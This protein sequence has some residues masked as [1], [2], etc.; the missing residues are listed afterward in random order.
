MHHK[1]RLW[2]TNLHT[3]FNNI[4]RKDLEKESDLLAGVLREC[5]GI[6]SDFG[7]PVLSS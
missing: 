4:L 6:Q 7:L 1:F 3:N 5:T 2:A